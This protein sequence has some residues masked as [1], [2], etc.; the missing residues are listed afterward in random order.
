MLQHEEQKLS[1]LREH[2]LPEPAIQISRTR[3]A[4][5]VLLCEKR[6]KQSLHLT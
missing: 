2:T 1:H 6:Q 3:K 4:I 5:K